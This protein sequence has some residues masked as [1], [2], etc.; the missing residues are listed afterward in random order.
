MP[1]EHRLHPATLIFDLARHARNFA[2]PA[3]LLIFGVSRSSGG[4]GGMFDA[5]PAGWEVWLPILFVPA[6]AVS[7]S[8]YLTFRWRCDERELVIRWGLLFRHERHVPYARIQNVDAVQNVFHR[9]F[10]VVE[11][12]VETGGGK[13][14]EARLS[15]LPRAAFGCSAHA[16]RTPCSPCPLSMLSTPSTL[17]LQRILSPRRFCV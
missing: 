8:R 6:A 1:S 16:R 13:E 9:L 11:V 12:R 17:R 3:V 15:V 7:V 14:E 2:L 5:I 4:P 10:S